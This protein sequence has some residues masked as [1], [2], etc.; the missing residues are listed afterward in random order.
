MHP[1]IKEGETVTV[2][3]LSSFD[4][5]RGDILL[6]IAGKKVIAHRVVSIKR[7]KNDFATHSKALN[8]KHIFIL[9]GDASL[10]CDDP[11]E[12]H[13]ILGKVVSV[14]RR[15]RSI[16][17]YSTSARMFRLAYTWASRLKR[18]MV[19]ILLGMKTFRWRQPS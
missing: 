5:K 16:D 7:E 12:A 8:G 13:Q 19:R 3:P 15:G 2:A 4:I 10:T 1:A 11:V 18:K 6:Y 14:E 9:R 17:L